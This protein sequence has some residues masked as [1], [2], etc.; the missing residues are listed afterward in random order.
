M[1]EGPGQ[2]GLAAVVVAAAAGVSTIIVSGRR[3]DGRRLKVAEELGATAIIDIDEEDPM[4]RVAA[5]TGGRM[6]DVVLDVTSS[7]DLSPIETAVACAKTGG[8]IVIAG[9]HREMNLRFD[10]GGFARKALTVQGVWGRERS[11]VF[12]AIGMLESG[13]Y[14]LAKLVTNHFGLDAV[15]EALLTVGREANYEALHVSVVP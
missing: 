9:V 5:V 10:A 12:G 13:K 7:S 4:D 6:V 14:P 11:A 15:E 8:R 3:S 2:E 1:I